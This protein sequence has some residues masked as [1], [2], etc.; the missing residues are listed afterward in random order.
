M[1]NN[2]NK[3]MKLSD[4]HGVLPPMNSDDIIILLCIKEDIDENTL[5][6]H[7]DYFFKNF[8][9]I[10]IHI[11]IIGNKLSLKEKLIIFSNSKYNI[12]VTEELFEYKNFS[13]TEDI[14]NKISIIRLNHFINLLNVPIVFTTSLNLLLDLNF[15]RAK[16]NESPVLIDKQ[17]SQRL[18]IDGKK[19]SISIIGSIAKIFLKDITYYKKDKNYQAE[20]IISLVINKAIEKK[21][22]LVQFIDTV[23]NKEIEI[24]DRK[25]KDKYLSCFWPIKSE[26]KILLFRPELTLPFKSPPLVTHIS[27]HK[28]NSPFARGKYGSL[29]DAWDRCYQLIED[30]FHSLGHKPITITRPGSE[31]TPKLANLTKADIVIVPHKQKFQFH[32]TTI[33]CF[34]LMQVAH[35]WLFTIDQNGWGAGAKNYPYDKFRNN[36]ADSGIFERYQEL[37]LKNN[38]SK[39]NQKERQP[40]HLLI[41][42]NKIPDKPF[43]FFPCQIPDDE[44][45]KY[46]S[47]VEESE[48][49][50]KL[51]EWANKK[52][53]HIVFKEHPA[54]PQSSKRFKELTNNDYT[55]W[56]DASVHDLLEN[57]F[58]LFTINSGVGHEA[59][60][61]SKPIVMFGSSEYDELSI[62]ANINL[63]DEAYAKLKSWNK[64][65]MEILYKKYYDWFIKDI[66]IDILDN[67]L[68]HASILRIVKKIEKS[69]N[70]QN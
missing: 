3:S 7:L 66:A 32:E 2:K 40:R 25:K 16:I 13:F 70:G 50:T 67:D 62:K 11:H 52:K 8:K 22:D 10:H 1:K 45:I 60:L 31:I 44:V 28:D 14:F 53:I 54:D 48:V 46:F 37:T 9:K 38:D 15:L 42:E 35:R 61:H 23:K 5:L 59:I 43:V 36:N 55:K 49:I 26:L 30:T 58:A 12:T 63:L 29:R 18:I 21:P 47:P 39:F 33:P 69:K 24:S 19:K 4:L 64:N 17:Y 57:C 51:S 34:F 56:S 6:I 20:N 65:E 68:A 27:D 41:Q